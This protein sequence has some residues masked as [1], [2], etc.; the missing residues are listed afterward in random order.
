MAG[1]APPGRVQAC[2][3]EP[4]CV[5]I[6]VGVVAFVVDAEVWAEDCM[7]R[8]QGTMLRAECQECQ[9]L[10]ASNQ[11]ETRWKQYCNGSRD[12][13]RRTNVSG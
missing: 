1:V 3:R 5:V 8:S 10:L 11:H 4:L 7:N 9:Q 2:R 12:M 13:K 6:G